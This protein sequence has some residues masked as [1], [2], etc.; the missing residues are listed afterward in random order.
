MTHA[1]G[2]VTTDRMPAEIAILDMRRH[3]AGALWGPKGF[4]SRL[5]TRRLDR[6]R[7]ARPGH[8]AGLRPGRVGPPGVRI[9]QFRDRPGV[10]PRV[11]GAARLRSGGGRMR[12]H[13]V[14]PSVPERRENGIG[15]KR[16]HRLAKRG[17]V[18]AGE[19]VAKLDQAARDRNPALDHAPAWSLDRWRR[20]TGYSPAPRPATSAAAVDGDEGTAAHRGRV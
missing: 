18:P 2:A 9:R 3:G 6:C 14:R 16:L 7:P 17:P 12:R 1:A 8:A 13:A 15:G 20:E 11:R 4:R 5:D 10:G 19:P